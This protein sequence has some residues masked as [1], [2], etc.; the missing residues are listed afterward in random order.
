MINYLDRCHRNIGEP[1]PKFTIERCVIWQI[2]G[3]FDFL[4]ECR[5]CAK[6]LLSCIGDSKKIAYTLCVAST[7]AVFFWNRGT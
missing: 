3:Y 6:Y 5:R 1:N 7:T 4:K 2:F